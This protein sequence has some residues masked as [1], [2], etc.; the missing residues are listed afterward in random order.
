[1]AT[2]ARPETSEPGALRPPLQHRSRASLERVLEAGQQLLEDA[3]WEGFT[4]QEVSRRAGVSIGSIYAR[5]PSKDALILAVYDRAMSAIAE[6]NDALLTPQE[7]WE[8]LEARELILV[9]TREMTRQVLEH[10][11]ILRV[12]M[13]RAPVDAMI[14]ARA[15][16]QIRGRAARW[17]EL[18]LSRREEISH[19]DPDLAIEVAFRMVLGA[20]Q[21]R[22]QFG[23]Q[24]G[25]YHEVDDEDLIVELGEAAAA[26]LLMPRPR[27]GR[28]QKKR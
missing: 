9:A 21:R 19:P 28:S 5:A 10:E 26:Y 8:G 17:E 18:I 11:S 7:Q 14:R 20:I 23:P 3:G 27:R 13:N 22:V 1:M 24:F 4:V 25:A 2:R 16:E 15:A 12:F 6:A